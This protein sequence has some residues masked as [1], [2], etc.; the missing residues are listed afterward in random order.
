MAVEARYFCNGGCGAV[1]TQEEY[2]KGATHCGENT[3]SM[4]QHPFEKG[5]YCTV[6]GKRITEEERNQH[7]H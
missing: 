7:Q 4:Y 3:C 1:K 6:E 5:L 2:E